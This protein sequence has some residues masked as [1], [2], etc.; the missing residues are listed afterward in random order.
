MTER[1]T[2]ELSAS[3]VLSSLTTCASLSPTSNRVR[4]APRA[5]RRTEP[6]FALA[7]ALKKLRMEVPAHTVPLSLCTYR[8]CGR[9]KGKGTEGKRGASLHVSLTGLPVEGPPVMDCIP[10]AAQR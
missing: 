3:I 1:L 10:T 7:T 6:L 9:A 2:P 5:V 8:L 4:A